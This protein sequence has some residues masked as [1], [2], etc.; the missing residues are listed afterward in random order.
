VKGRNLNRAA[1]LLSD[2]AE[3]LES[4]AMGIDDVTDADPLLS[5]GQLA[6]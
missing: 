4:C 2:Y 3:L 1:W 5:N 6:R